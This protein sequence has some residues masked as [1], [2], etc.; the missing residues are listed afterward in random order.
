ML[1]LLAVIVTVVFVSPAFGQDS[2]Y[3]TNHYGTRAELLGGTVVGGVT[4]LS[5]T[6]YNPGAISRARDSKL[7]LTT[8]AV[9]ISRILIAEGAGPG[10][11]LSSTQAGSAP[12]MFAARITGDWLGKN[13]MAVSFLTRYDF[14]MNSSQRI[15]SDTD[16]FP[17]A[18]GPGAFTGELKLDTDLG[19]QWYG[20][21]FARPVARNTGI[22]ISPYFVY[23][24]QR[25]RTQLVSQAVA[26]QGVN[27]GSITTI[28]EYTYW[29]VRTLF[30]IGVAI[31]ARPFSIGFTVTTP[32]IG[33]FGD[34][35]RFMDFA[36]VTTDSIGTTPPTSDMASTNQEQISPD[37]R[38]PFSTALGATYRW[39]NTTLNATVEWF[40]KIPLYTVIDAQPFVPQTG[41]DP[42][43]TDVVQEMKSVFNWGIGVE[44]IIH[45]GL[46]FY[47]ALFADRTGYVSKETTMLSA[48][49]WDIHHISLGSVFNFKG[50]DFTLGLSYGRGRGTSD[51]FV[52]FSGEGENLLPD[53]PPQ[54][55]VR[56]DRFKVI[57]GLSFPYDKDA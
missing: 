37:Y 6:F 5:S 19:E 54:T 2:Q 28:D 12:S 23:R 55:S 16:F 50:I 53:D 25:F 35:H 44:Q 9:E 7:V 42:V 51:R 22:G 24:S 52:N 38:S 20:A 34:A 40:A 3:W 45:E 15:V 14:K 36:R 47:G 33:F 13:S 11:D 29:H 41:G 27:G 10:S 49:T 30:K 57:F 46:S 8:S 31:E 56:Y 17:N 21:T 43:E 39:Q 4:D 48:S 32:S 18:A 26:T 1:R